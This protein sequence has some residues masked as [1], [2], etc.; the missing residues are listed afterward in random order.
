M[1]YSGSELDNTRYMETLHGVNALLSPKPALFFFV[2]AGYRS[3]HA[4]V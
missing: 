1:K 4:N 3:P 2:I